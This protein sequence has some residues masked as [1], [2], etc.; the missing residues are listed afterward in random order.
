MNNPKWILP[1][2][3]VS[4]FCSTSLWFSGNGIMADLVSDFNLAIIFGDQ[5][6][7]S[8]LTLQFLTGFFLPEYT[9]S[10]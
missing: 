8:L 3:V 2:I 5:G 7:T 1:V 6:L 9:L 10:G 4:Q